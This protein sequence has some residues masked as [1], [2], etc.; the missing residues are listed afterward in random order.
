MSR[1]ACSG[2]TVGVKLSAL[3]GALPVLFAANLAQAQS[4]P[5]ERSHGWDRATNIMALSAAG[6]QLVMP[7]VFY[8]DPEVTVGWKA[9]WHLSVLAP[10]MTLATL[11]LLNEQ[12]LKES[13]DSPSPDCEEDVPC[14]SYGMLSS[15]SFLAFSALGQGVG[16]F[17]VDTT[18]WSGGRFNVGSFFGN[19]AV[20]AVLATITGVGRS[21]G[22]WE[23]GGQ[24]WGSA[25]IGLG[26]GFGIGLLYA[27]L[28]RPECGYTGNLICW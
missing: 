26:L 19:V 5:P 11:T 1:D 9:R 17:L 28:Q 6:L 4:A 15:Q 22:N 27:T 21:A 24:V 16:V 2:R 8:S 14:D 18:K 23:S 12:V 13:F 20:P 10:S 7:R 25:G 3:L